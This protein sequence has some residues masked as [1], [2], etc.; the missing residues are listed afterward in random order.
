MKIHEYQAKEL[1]KAAD[2]AVLAGLPAFSA[3]QAKEAAERLA[4]PVY[5]VKAQIHAG[6]RGKAGGVKI[7]HS[8]DE[9]ETLA[10]GMLGKCLVTKQTGPEGQTVSRLYIESGAEIA[11]ELYASVLV[12]RAAQKLCLI[13][14][15][16]G[17]MDIEEVAQKAPDAVKR[18][19]IDPVKGAEPGAFLEVA[20]AVGLEGK[21]AELAAAYFEGLCRLFEDKD[22]S[23]IEINPL[24]VLADG[25]VCALDAKM[26][27]DDNALF[28]HPDIAALR[29]VTQEDPTEVKAQESHLSFVNLDGNIACMVNGAGLAMATMDS[30]NLYGGEPANFLDVGGS[31]DAERVK[32]AFELMLAN[33]K[34][35]AVLVNIFGGI[36]H[37]DTI[38]QGVTE[39][40]RAVQLK[41]P[42]VVR[43]H[44]TNEELG[45]RILAES[46]LPVITAVTMAEAAEKAV[47]CAAGKPVNSSEAS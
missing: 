22:A 17:G 10:A 37:C 34:V 39:A 32:T 24:A 9:V 14:C 31:A 40:C 11:R 26:I 20:R 8:A 35:K 23:L 19:L 13:A 6:G 3:A 27:F 5:A 2:L 46:G 33:P 15:A 30:I 42:L 28:R 25:T 21:T 4:G 16:S 18:L 47:A 7:A 44:G 41:V 1:L 12:D 38:A 29:D 36:M 45:C 43:M